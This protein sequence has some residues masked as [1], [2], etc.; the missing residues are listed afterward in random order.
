MAD[1][2][3]SVTE[4]FQ[5][6]EDWVALLALHPPQV[7]AL[8]VHRVLMEPGME[9]LVKV[10]AVELEVWV[11]TLASLQMPLPLEDVDRSISGTLRFTR[12]GRHQHPILVTVESPLSC[13]AAL[14][15]PKRLPSMLYQRYMDGLSASE[16][17]VKMGM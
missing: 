6:E 9:R 7:R 5:V 8:L 2:G 14:V 11:H 15:V 3:V 12:R 1:R 13:P 17:R 10:A 4:F 16:S